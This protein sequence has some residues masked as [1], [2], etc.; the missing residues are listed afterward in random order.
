MSDFDLIPASYRAQC[1]ARDS[2][3]MAA[4]AAGLVLFIGVASAVGLRLL[5]SHTTAELA[6]LKIDSNAREVI[7]SKYKL[8][9]A[10]RT[11]LREQGAVMAAL[12]RRGATTTLISVVEQARATLPLWLKRWEYYGGTPG[13]SDAQR[14]QLRGDAQSHDALS[15]FVEALLAA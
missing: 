7:A 13:K 3:R 11:K 1:V 5:N 15:R 9:V 12:Q 10:A 2:L 4:I 14:M 8:M 6:S